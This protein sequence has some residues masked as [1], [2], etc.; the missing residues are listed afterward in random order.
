MIGVLTMLV[1]L[2]DLVMRIPIVRMLTERK[3]ERERTVD[4]VRELKRRQEEN[5]RRVQILD[6]MSYP[7]THRRTGPHDSH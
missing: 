5:E 2:K 3:E 6:W 1:S 7:H 4:L